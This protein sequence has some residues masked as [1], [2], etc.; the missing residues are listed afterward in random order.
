MKVRINYT[1]D[2]DPDGWRRQYGSPGTDLAEI[3][4]DIQAYAETL[5]TDHCRD[6]GLLKD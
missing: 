4:A 2:V 6:L 3:R 5:M 1:I